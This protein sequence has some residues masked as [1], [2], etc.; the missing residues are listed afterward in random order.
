LTVWSPPRI[1]H[2]NLKIKQTNK[3]TKTKKNLLSWKKQFEVVFVTLFNFNISFDFCALFFRFIQY[4]L[5]FRGLSP[6]GRSPGQRGDD[7]NGGA[8]SAT[9]GGK[10]SGG[11]GGDPSI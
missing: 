2:I 5:D 8:G 3:Q 9:E 1:L 7:D 10:A 6:R 4:N 11:A